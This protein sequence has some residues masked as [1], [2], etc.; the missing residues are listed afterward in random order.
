MR[1]H[2]YEKEFRLQ[3]HFHASQSHFRKKGSA[4]RLALKQIHKGIR[5]W[6]IFK[7]SELLNQEVF[8][9]KLP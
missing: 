5:K 1:I 7:T 2:C 4:S 3:F 8:I 9:E 6:P